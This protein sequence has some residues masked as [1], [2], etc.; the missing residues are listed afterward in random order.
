MSPL[1]INGRTEKELIRCCLQG[2]R[3]AQKEIF[4]MYSGK[5]LGMC[6]RYTKNR[7][8]AEDILQDGFV[9]V[10][11]HLAEFEF[12]GSFEGWVRRIMIHTALRNLKKKY[13]SM[14]ESGLDH[15]TEDV[16]MP[17]VFA[18]LSEAELIKLISSLPDGYRAVFN[19]FAIEGFSHKE[20]GEMLGI[21]ESTS[22]SQLTKARKLLQE[23]VLSHYNMAV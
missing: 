17:D 13:V 8:E 22:R 20:I 21:E 15:I 1:L 14:E 19:L 7:Q 12:H 3:A 11:T 10:F 4:Q 23:M 6:M 2:E 16:V 18:A 9:K 5:M